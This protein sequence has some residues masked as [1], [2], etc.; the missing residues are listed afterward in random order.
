M[1]DMCVEVALYFGLEAL[2]MLAS[3]VYVCDYPHDL[4]S[5]KDHILVQESCLYVC[6]LDLFYA[7]KVYPFMPRNESWW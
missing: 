2:S 1:L 3:S 5:S 6:M 4:T 7:L